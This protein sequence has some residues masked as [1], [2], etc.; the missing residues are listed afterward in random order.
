MIRYS[1]I[2]KL[3]SQRVFQYGYVLSGMEY[4]KEH[5]T[6]HNLGVLE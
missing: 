3:E 5:P 1:H 4:R 2:W 6:E